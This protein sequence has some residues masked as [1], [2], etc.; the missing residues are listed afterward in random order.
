ML[1]TGSTPLNVFVQN[2]LLRANDRLNP[3]SDRVNRQFV[4]IQ[5]EEHASIHSFTSHVLLN[6]VV[7]QER[8]RFSIPVNRRNNRNR[9]SMPDRA[10][11]FNFESCLAHLIAEIQAL[12]LNQCRPVVGKREPEPWRGDRFD[13]A[14]MHL[15][16]GHAE[17]MRM[18]FIARVGPRPRAN[19]IAFRLDK[20]FR[21]RHG[22]HVVIHADQIRQ[23]ALG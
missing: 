18:H 16:R 13:H 17:V 10:S 5:V 8:R 15:Q 23:R 11:F 7:K 9:K 21:L 20:R 3:T 14:A 22:H 2:N 4:V 6:T 1:L 12:A 19:D